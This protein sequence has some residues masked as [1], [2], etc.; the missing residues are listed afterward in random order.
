[1]WASVARYWYSKASH[2]QPAV[3][4][5]YRHLGTI[6]GLCDIEKLSYYT[7]SLCAP[8]PCRFAKDL[9]VTLPY[10]EASNISS[11]NLVSSEDESALLRVQ[12]VLFGR[13]GYHCLRRMLDNWSELL[14]QHCRDSAL[15][16]DRDILSRTL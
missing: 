8:T 4:R 2:R 6:P 3:G 11:Q 5:L 14:A 10:F 13:N 1:M 15:H 12:A 9:I 16:G 7:K